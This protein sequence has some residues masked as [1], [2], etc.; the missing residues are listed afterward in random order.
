MRSATQKRHLQVTSFPKRGWHPA[1]FPI[2]SRPARPKES[3]Q[4][5]PQAWGFRSRDQQHSLRSSRWRLELKPS[6]EMHCGLSTLEEASTRHYLED[7]DPL[8]MMLIGSSDDHNS[9]AMRRVNKMPAAYR[10]TTSESE[11]VCCMPSTDKT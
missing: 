11:S 4:T 1:G 9:N 3:A 8:L 6:N 7:Q 10:T 2:P 5:A